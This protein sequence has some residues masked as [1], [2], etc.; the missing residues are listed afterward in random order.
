MASPSLTEDRDYVPSTPERVGSYIPCGGVFAGTAAAGPALLPAPSSHTAMTMLPFHHHQALQQPCTVY[1]Y[2]VFLGPAPHGSAQFPYLQFQH[3]EGDRGEATSASL[4]QEE[5]EPEKIGE[6]E[7]EELVEERRDLSRSLGRRLRR[8]RQQLRRYT[9]A[10]VQPHT[11]PKSILTRNSRNSR[12]IFQEGPG[13]RA[14]ERASAA[15]VP[16]SSEGP[17]ESYQTS[18]FSSEGSRELMRASGPLAHQTCA[19]DVLKDLGK[20]LVNAHAA[21][22]LTRVVREAPYGR[23]APRGS[24]F[25]KVFE[26]LIYAL[27]RSAMNP[28]GKEVYLSMLLRVEAE[29]ELLSQ[30]SKMLRNKLVADFCVLISSPQSALVLKRAMSV[31]SFKHMLLDAL[32]KDIVSIVCQ[33]GDVGCDFVSGLLRKEDSLKVAMALLESQACFQRL[34][35]DSKWSSLLVQASSLGHVH[36]REM[37]NR[38]RGCSAEEFMRLPLHIK[39]AGLWE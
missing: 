14:G 15:A 28:L 35:R 9:E 31:A 32:E 3:G 4:R 21:E 39:K 36:R 37:A 10:V 19:L 29:A 16:S 38:L 23:A 27:P 2:P 1:Y 26:G 12:H 17:R 13:E 8:K 7:M 20:C 33:G 34:S 25:E 18:I 22:V 24:C 5:E 6:E 11:S 30:M